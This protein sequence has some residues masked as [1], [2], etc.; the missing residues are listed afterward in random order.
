MHGTALR[1]NK[2]KIQA[3]KVLKAYNCKNITKNKSAVPLKR[4][5]RQY[6][7]ESLMTT[8][9]SVE[10]LN[11]N[12]IF[13]KT[14]PALSDF[15]MKIKHGEFLSLLG[16]SGCGKSTLLRIIAG[17]EEPTSGEVLIDGAD[18]SG[19]PANKR[20]VNMVFQSYSLFPHMNI[21]DNIAFGPRTAKWSESLIKIEI[22]N[23]LRLVGLSGFEKRFPNQLS[24]GQKQR[25]AVAR[26]LINK[27]KVL[28]LDEPLGALD[29]QIRKQM[30]LELRKIHLELKNTFVYVTH[31]QE[32]ALVMSDRIVIMQSGRII[33]SGSPREI[34]LNPQN[35]FAARFIGES[36]II[37]ASTTDKTKGYAQTD[38]GTIK[39]SAASQN[40]DAGEVNQ[41]KVYL[42]VRPESL[43]I[44]TFSQNKDYENV[45]EGVVESSIFL[46]SDI[47]YEVRVP[48]SI[49]LNIRK[50]Y[51][52]RDRIFKPGEEIRI[53]FNRESVHL[54]REQN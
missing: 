35:E 41:G 39:L 4:G 45:L 6:K 8:E 18:M 49:I 32:E 22:E 16:P 1:W 48:G 9:Y 11:I 12:K 21:Y 24:G 3:N 15:S 38:A 7:K 37:E 19:I 30:Q 33:Q 46:G 29:L 43:D 5:S 31:D 53:G 52:H 27:P 42:L 47:R 25:V 51:I 40:T 34:Y 36:N 23:M 26:A 17:L 20:P 54:I 44:F 2:N 10:C 28:L 14:V 13:S 50:S